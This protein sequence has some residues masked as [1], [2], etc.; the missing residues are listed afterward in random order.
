MRLSNSFY[1]NT[2]KS[3]VLSLAFL[4]SWNTGFANLTFVGQVCSDPSSDIVKLEISSENFEDIGSFQFTFNWDV[5][6]LEYTSLG[7]YGLPHFSQ[8]NYGTVFV[9]EGVVNFSWHDGDGVGENLEDG[10][11]L[12]TIF[13]KKKTDDDP[14]FQIDGSKTAMEVIQITNGSWNEMDAAFELNPEPCSFDP[15]PSTSTKNTPITNLSAQ[16]LPNILLPNETPTLTI[17]GNENTKLEVSIFNLEGKLLNTQPILHLSEKSE[18][19]LDIPQTSGLF[20]IRILDEQGGVK[21]LKLAV[22]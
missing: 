13:F 12:F 1:S 10:T 14:N 7:E 19:Q 6:A 17:Q 9:D 5:N 2:V 8:Q 11:H 18:I 22:Q 21:T 4:I 3:F 15:N 16:V 20:F